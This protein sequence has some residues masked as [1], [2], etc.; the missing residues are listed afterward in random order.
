MGV[1][2]AG[3]FLQGLG[4]GGQTVALYVLIA[5]VYPPVT[6][7]RIFGAFASAW[8]L[9]SMVGPFAAGVVADVLSWHWVFLGVVVLVA[10]ATAMIAP[11]A[12]RPSPG[13]AERPGLRRAAR[14]RRRGGRGR[15]R[16]C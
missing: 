2:V 4:A 8:V 10:V 3:R 5:K 7:I 14:H 9:P 11:A 13:R 16:L 6:H 15:R 12:A 1:F